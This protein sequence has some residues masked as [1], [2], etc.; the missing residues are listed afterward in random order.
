MPVR[1]GRLELFLLPMR[2]LILRV[3]E[4]LGLHHG[5]T[6]GRATRVLA[7]RASSFLLGFICF[8]GWIE[9]LYHGG[10]EAVTLVCAQEIGSWQVEESDVTTET[11][12]KL[13]N[14][15]PSRRVLRLDWVLR[16]L[17]AQRSKQVCCA[18]RVLVLVPPHVFVGQQL[19]EACNRVVSFNANAAPTS[20]KSELV[21]V[22]HIVAEVI[23]DFLHLIVHS[24]AL[25]SWEC[26]LLLLEGDVH[27]VG[28]FDV[29]L[30]WEELRCHFS[31]HDELIQDLL[32]FNC[33]H[34]VRP[35]SD[36]R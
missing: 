3:G 17:D 25:A 8:A 5:P 35:A 31:D 14:C 33:R 15:G 20:N 21:V 28:I 7:L 13:V 4:R 29:T 36:V 2:F 18:T 26:E 19:H 11:A 22:K 34:T 6:A 9:L 10:L 30:L 16:K 23:R 24:A 27:D 32:D 1:D 12:Q